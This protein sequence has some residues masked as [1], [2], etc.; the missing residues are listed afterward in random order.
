MLRRLCLSLLLALSVQS[1]RAD[2]I[3]DNFTARA[4]SSTVSFVYSYTTNSPVP[5]SGGGELSVCGNSFRLSGDGMELWCDGVSLWSVDE[6]SR[7][8]VIEAVATSDPYS[9]NP[10][11]YL[12]NAQTAFTVVSSADSKFKGRLCH[13]VTLSPKRKTSVSQLKLFFAG[14]DLIG[15]SVRVSDGTVTEFEIRDLAFS[16]SKQSFSFDSSRLDSSWFVTDLR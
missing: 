13:C 9:V 7:E 14:Q 8:L 5:V 11:L 16:S 1:A 4:D 15:A 3:L 6:D 12:T 2:R 10:A